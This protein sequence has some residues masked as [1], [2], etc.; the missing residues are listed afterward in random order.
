MH[1]ATIR[2]VTARRAPA[3]HSRQLAVLSLGLAGHGRSASNLP[4]LTSD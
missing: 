1:A 4:Q 2:A 3:F